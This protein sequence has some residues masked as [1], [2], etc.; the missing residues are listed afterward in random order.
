MVNQKITLALLALALLSATCHAQPMS[1]YYETADSLYW[2]RCTQYA[3][4]DSNSGVAYFN[5][6]VHGDL[7]PKL[8]SI[9]INNSIYNHAVGLSRECESIRDYSTAASLSFIMA[10]RS[11]GYSREMAAYIRRFQR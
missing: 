2:G 4:T 3:K 1:G 11:G 7:C 10:A 6:R 8:D 9:S 5:Y